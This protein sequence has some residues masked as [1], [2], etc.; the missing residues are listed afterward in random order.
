MNT[1]EKPIVLPGE[2]IKPDHRLMVSGYMILENSTTD[3]S[4][5]TSGEPARV[6]I[7]RGYPVL[8]KDGR[9]AGKVAAIVQNE[10]DGPAA[11]LLLCRLPA[12]SGYLVVRRQQ[13]V[14]VEGGI[15]K[16]CLPLAEFSSLPEWHAPG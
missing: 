15:V 2:T 11:F 14:T 8:S 10:L 1:P 9:N 12:Q 3:G 13:V 5:A 4:G 7:R 16:L 6:E